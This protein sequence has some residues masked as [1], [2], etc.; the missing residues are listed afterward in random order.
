MDDIARELSVSKSTVSKALN[1][2]KDVSKAMRQ[3]VL[4]KA[5]E[6]GYSRIPRSASAQRIALFITNMEYEKPED[7][8]YDIV[9]GFRKAAEPSGFVV[10]LIPLD[11]SF[12]ERTHYDEY[13]VANNYCGGLFLGLSLVDPWIQEFEICRTPTVLYDNYIRGNPNVSYIGVDNREGMDLAVEYLHC[14]GHRKIGYLGSA[15][16]AYIYKQRFQSFVIAMEEHGLTVDPDLTGITYHI[17]EC[18]SLHL[19]RLLEAH[20]TAIIC[21]HDMLAN[22][23]MYHCSELGLRVP[24]DVSILGFDDLPLCRYTRPALSTIRQDRADLGKSAFFALTNLLNKVPVGTFLLH[25]TLIRRDSCTV[26]SE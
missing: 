4:E 1:G 15:H 9:V 10:D 14:L 23:V 2:A 13:M 22:S 17:S 18:L 26:A 19:P 3:A 21:S 6:L 7:F 24:E 8:G 16:Q 11:I 25:A 20:C 5:V 12:Q